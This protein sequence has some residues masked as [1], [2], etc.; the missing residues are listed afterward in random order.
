MGVHIEIKVNPNY[1]RKE[2]DWSLSNPNIIIRGE[3][4][5]EGCWFAREG[6][7]WYSCLIL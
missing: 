2:H 3:T 6:T 5:T 1:Q 7:S 4:G